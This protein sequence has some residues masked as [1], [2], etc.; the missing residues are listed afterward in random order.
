M[1]HKHWET[2]SGRWVKV[3]RSDNGGE[4]IGTHWCRHYSAAVSTVL[5]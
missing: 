2:L 3:F 1:I 4:F 5:P